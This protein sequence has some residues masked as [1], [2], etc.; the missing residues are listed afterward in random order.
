[1]KHKIEFEVVMGGGHKKK[2]LKKLRRLRQKSRK[3][4]VGS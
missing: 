2:P 1:M 4:D 3:G